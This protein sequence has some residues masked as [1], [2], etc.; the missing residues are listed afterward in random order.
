MTRPV[1]L[2]AVAGVAGL[3]LATFGAPPLH[4][5]STYDLLAAQDCLAGVSCDG[6]HASL[7]ELQQ[8]QG[9]ILLLAGLQTLGL[10]INGIHAL[11]VGL[12]VMAIALA[13]AVVARRRGTRQATLAALVMTAFT[14]ASAEVPL[15]WNPTL[16]PLPTVVLGVTLLRMV[17]APQRTARWSSVV[18]ASLALLV[19]IEAHIVNV[20]AVPVLV[21]VVTL[22]TARLEL[23]V[24]AALLPLSLHAALSPHSVQVN[25]DVVGAS[26]LVA[27]AAMALVC[28]WFLGETM[29]RRSRDWARDHR[30]DRAMLLLGAGWPAALWLVGTL[31]GHGFSLRYAAVAAFPLAWAASAHGMKLLQHL[32]G[33]ER[34]PRLGAKL[35]LA[36]VLLQSVVP[37]VLEAGVRPHKR[38]SAAPR[39]G[40]QQV[41]AVA[42]NLADAGVWLADLYGRA[43]IPDRYLFLQGA[44]L[45]V[46][47]L[48]RPRFDGPA[49]RLVWLPEGK[50]PDGSALP[51]GW[52][53]EKDAAM[54]YLVSDTV[55]PWVTLDRFEVCTR[56]DSGEAECVT[57][58]AAAWGTVAGGA[59]RQARQ[60]A[61]PFIL[62]VERLVHRAREAGRGGEVE[63]RLPIT[64]SN[65]DRVRH[66]RVLRSRAEPRW[67]IVAVGTS[68][69]DSELRTTLTRR[70]AGQ[71]LVLSA[72]LEA[73]QAPVFPPSLLELRPGEEAIAAVL[74][75]PSGLDRLLRTDTD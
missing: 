71:V 66:V 31:A 51:T 34:W 13:W 36:L 1:A 24:A 28:A 7:A 27:G 10:G 32:D 48:E 49:I 65:D 67:T 47:A 64:V 57:V 29:A 44:A 61:S 54:P 53:I 60:F 70:D 42:S 72:P 73:D 59:E 22:G 40:Q 56:P 35:V 43:Q 15:L 9:W 30:T 74:R 75:R 20:L 69:P 41:V 50:L 23:A 14:T 37:P 17:E 21:A 55:S 4:V 16:L 25:V 46:P 58:D 3:Y 6:H 62:P 8:G 45:S 38:T 2:I 63:F 19:A 33:L 18:V 5:D 26:V 11:M 68:R 12:H 39:L 52:R